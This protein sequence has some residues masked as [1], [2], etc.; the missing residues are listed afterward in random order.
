MRVRWPGR[1]GGV[2]V[3][4]QLSCLRDTDGRC[5]AQD[6]NLEQGS[7]ERM[8]PVMRGGTIG[9]RSRRT[10]RDGTLSRRHSRVGFVGPKLTCRNDGALLA[11]V[12]DL[13]ELAGQDSVRR[14]LFMYLR[15]GRRFLEPLDTLL[16]GWRP[17]VIAEH[18]RLLG[19]HAVCGHAVV[20]ACPRCASEVLVEVIHA[21]GTLVPVLAGADPTHVRIPPTGGQVGT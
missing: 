5:W 10:S 6:R 2:A 14:H 17:S 20:V 11:S 15:A 18:L 9:S 4:E 16:P 8:R 21:A 1:G 13:P 7:E 3:E 12:V 19:S